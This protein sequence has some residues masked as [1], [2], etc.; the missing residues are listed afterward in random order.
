M[1]VSLNLR[2]KSEFGRR[3]GLTWSTLPT[4]AYGRCGT[5]CLCAND[6]AVYEAVWDTYGGDWAKHVSTKKR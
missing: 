2:K 3:R 5:G 6:D 4:S 1:R